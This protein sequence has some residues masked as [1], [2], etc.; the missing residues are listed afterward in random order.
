MSSFIKRIRS[1]NKTTADK[2]GQSDV[3]KDTWGLYRPVEPDFLSRGVNDVARMP[4]IPFVGFRFCM[5]NQTQVLT[6]DGWKYFKDAS[7]DDDVLTMNEQTE[8][9]SYVKPKEK[10]EYEYDGD[11]LYYGT[12]G[13]DF[14]VIPEHQMLVKSMTDLYDGYSKKRVKELSWERLQAKDLVQKTYYVKRDM[15]WIGEER[16]WIDFPE[17]TDGNGKV[18]AIKRISMDDWLSFLGWYISEGCCSKYEVAITQKKDEHKVEIKYVMDRIRFGNVAYKKASGQF[19]IGSVHL[20]SILNGDV[21]KRGEKKIPEFIFGLSSRQIG[22]FLESFWKGDGTLCSNGKTKAYYTVYAGLADGIHELVLKTGKCATVNRRFSKDAYGAKWYYEISEWSKNRYAVLQTKKIVHKKYVGKVYCFNVEP[23][24]TLFVR[25]NGR[26]MWTGNCFDLYQYSDLLRTIMRSLVHET[27]RN[28]LIIQKNFVNKCNYCGAEYNTATN[29][30]EVCTSTSLREPDKSQYE[31]LREWQKKVNY[32]DQNLLE[33]CKELDMDMNIVD[34]AFAS[35]LKRYD[36]DASGKMVGASAIEFLRAHPERCN[37]VFD[38]NGRFGYTDD[39]KIVM[40]CLEHRDKHHLMKSE[41][42]EESTCDK[43]GKKM[44]PAYFRV[45]KMGSKYIYYTKGEMEHLKKF[46]YGLGYGLPPMF[47]VWQ[48]V[49][50]LMKMDFF[51][52]SAY[53]LERPPKGLLLMKGNRESIDKAWRRLQEEARTN[54]HMIYPLVVDGSKDIKNVMEWLD[55]TLKSDDINFIE[56]RDELRRTIG[57]LW[58]VMP[59]FHGDTSAGMGL[60]NEGLQILV[61]NRAVEVEQGIFNDKVFPWLCRNIG[62]TDW[63]YKCVPNEGRDQ[64]AKLQREKM[65]IDNANALQAMGYI[66]EAKLTEDGIDFEIID[67]ETQEE[68]PSNTRM[69]F[70]KPVST[71]EMQRFS[72]EPEHGRPKID[73]QENSGAVAGVRNPK[74]TAASASNAGAAVA[75]QSKGM[76]DLK[77]EDVEWFTEVF[78]EEDMNILKEGWNKAVAHRFEGIASSRYGALEI[79]EFWKKY[80]GISVRKSR[81]INGIIYKAVLERNTDKGDIVTQVM[82]DTGIDEYKAD[83]IVRTELANIALEAREL[84]YKGRTDVTKFLYPS[85]GDEDECEICKKAIELSK[86]GVSIERLKQIAKEVSPSSRG[87]VIHVNC[88]HTFIRKFGDKQVWETKK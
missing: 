8:E 73:D 16:Q 20:C 87:L 83:M 58:G 67:P 50:I 22:V 56:F 43:C 18:T 54:P 77:K 70:R 36:F 4:T 6:K 64:V 44:Y 38:K 7:V 29:T 59:I 51:M 17:Y 5:D 62:V 35:V 28:G 84:A 19:V 27:F 85:I 24:H 82:K 81:R 13:L 30:C 88:R 69:T 41:E 74:S 48:K 42:A 57:A 26:V 31:Y 80:S 32:N 23:N 33:V 86:E 65:R 1:G 75:T 10:I 68:V 12:K 61:T 78:D 49:Q 9:I 76:T 55:L 72:G 40:F 47:S 63:T 79:A 3:D 15:N 34:N 71:R 11:M 52:L 37:F 66:A 14:A 39:G 2:K 45:T 60:A 53:H 25:R 21:G 46:S